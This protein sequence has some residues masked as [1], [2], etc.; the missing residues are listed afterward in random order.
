[1]EIGELSRAIGRLGLLWPKVRKIEER[2][3]IGRALSVAEQRRL[4]DGL[5]SRQ[6]QI[7]RTLIPLL[8]LTGMRAGEATSLHWSRWI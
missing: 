3:D 5:D 8:L 4:L 1:M 2:K 6:S 7:S